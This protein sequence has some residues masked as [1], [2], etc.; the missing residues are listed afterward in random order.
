MRTTNIPEDESGKQSR[1]IERTGT[2]LVDRMLVGTQLGAGGAVAEERTVVTAG[3]PVY[4]TLR[5][6]DSPV[7]LRTGAIWY[8][9]RG[10]R[11]AVEK[12]EMN[13]AKV[14]TFAL[15]Q[16]LTPGQYHV[17]GYWGANLAGDTKFEV[18]AKT[19]RSK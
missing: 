12:K 14:A 7:G 4:L 8:D 9:H 1:V 3:E 5:L 13:G 16:K 15:A 2:T 18:V 11:V 10:R 17:E 6:R 19:K